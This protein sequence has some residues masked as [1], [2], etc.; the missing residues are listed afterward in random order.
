MVEYCDVRQCSGHSHHC[1]LCGNLTCGRDPRVVWKRAGVERRQDRC[2]VRAKNVVMDG[3]KEI[4]ALERRTD[5]EAAE[6][7]VRKWR[8]Y[9]FRAEKDTME[10]EERIFCVLEIERAE[11]ALHLREAASRIGNRS[12][13]VE[14]RF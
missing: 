5:A 11:A 8:G 14:D 3:K 10:K 9:A 2:M 4:A 1:V 6:L 12:R 13:W 7:G